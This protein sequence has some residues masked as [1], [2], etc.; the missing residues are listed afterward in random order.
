MYVFLMSSCA[1]VISD[2]IRHR[3]DKDMPLEAVFLDPDAYRGKVLIIGGTIVNSVNK[4]EGTYIEVVEKP[5][6]YRGVPVYS[7][8]SFGRFLVVHD[9]FLD[10]AIFSK[11]RHITVAGEII[12]KEMRKLDEMDYPYLFIKSMEVRLL[13]PDR[14]TPIHFGIGVSHSF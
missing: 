10:T 5:L 4:K 12:G 1:H 11:G 3:A 14:G 9:G 8:S 7:D 13:D 6:N 2:D